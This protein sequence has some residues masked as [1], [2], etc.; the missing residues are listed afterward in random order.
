VVVS[1]V[2][3][4]VVAVVVVTISTST[5]FH[6]PGFEAWVSRVCG[7]RARRQGGRMRG[8]EAAKLGTPPGGGDRRVAS[9]HPKPPFFPGIVPR[10]I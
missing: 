3:I 7:L 6:G 4:I 8:R 2:A 10:R 1:V 5:I 9:F